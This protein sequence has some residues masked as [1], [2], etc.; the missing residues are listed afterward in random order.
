M[1]VGQD[2]QCA[3]CIPLVTMYSIMQSP[4]IVGHQLPQR[5]D[6]LF[7]SEWIHF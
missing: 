4:D 1:A 2:K 5:K 3:R 7:V 6:R